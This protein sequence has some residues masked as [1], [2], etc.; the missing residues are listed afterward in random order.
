M[1]PA[2]PMEAEFEHRQAAQRGHDRLLLRFRLK[3]PRSGDRL[4]CEESRAEGAQL[5]LRFGR[6]ESERGNGLQHELPERLRQLR[7]GESFA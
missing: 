4:A 2:Q 6:E 7:R 3:P 1:P 5:R